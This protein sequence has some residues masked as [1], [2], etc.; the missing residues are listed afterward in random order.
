MNQ[1]IQKPQKA[2]N[3]AFRKVKPNRKNFEL[4]CKNLSSMIEQI[5]DLRNEKFHKN[6]VIEFLKNSYYSPDYGVNVKGNID[7][8]I[9]TG[10]D[11]N[12]PVGVLIEAKKPAN[13]SEIADSIFP[14]LKEPLEESGWT[15]TD[16][17]TQRLIA[18]IKAAGVSFGEYV[19]GK[20]YRGVLTGLNEAFVIDATTRERLI[21]EDPKSEEVIK[22]FLAGRDIKRYQEPVSDKYLILFKCGD[23]KEW[24]GDLSESEAWIKLSEKYPAVCE[25]LKPFEAKAKKRTDKGQ[26]WWELRACVYYDEFEKAKLMYPDISVKPEFTYDTNSSYSANTGYMIASD[27]KELLG[28]LNSVVFYFFYRN[29][30]NSIRGGYMRFFTQYVEQF[31]IPQQPSPEIESLVTTILAKKKADPAADTSVEENRID[32]LVFELYGLT[33]EEIQIVRGAV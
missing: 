29:T 14:V 26:Y 33:E 2:L 21:E 24:F 12:S 31:S 4:F 22:P 6:L 15:L 7:L 27:K 18:K 5:D 19:D 13:R 8:V 1:T 16:S 32:D 17:T 25:W 20:I 28:L 10:K 23:T 30:T 3:K 9:H 11:A